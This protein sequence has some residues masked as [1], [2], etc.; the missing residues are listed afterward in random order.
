MRLSDNNFFLFIYSFVLMYPTE[1]DK[2]TNTICVL[3]WGGLY[4]LGK[5]QGLCKM[6]KMIPCWLKVTVLTQW[7]HNS[8]K[9]LGKILQVFGSC[10]FW[11]KDQ[12]TVCFLPLFFVPQCSRKEQSHL[13]DKGA[14]INPEMK[15]CVRPKST[16]CEIT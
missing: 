10:Y 12:L 4:D 5:V 1:S 2:I 11:A 9:S 6:E 7:S 3:L 13:Q 8:W 14:P 16:V 15:A